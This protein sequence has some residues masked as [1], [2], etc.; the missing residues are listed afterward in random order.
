MQT[1]EINL[2]NDRPPLSVNAVREYNKVTEYLS[3][4]PKRRHYHYNHKELEH[5]ASVLKFT[6]EKEVNRLEK[7]VLDRI[8]FSAFI[9][10]ISDFI[11]K[12]KTLVPIPKYS[13][14]SVSGDFALFSDIFGDLLPECRTDYNNAK[15]RMNFTTHS[16]SQYKQAYF[17][18]SAFSQH[19][20]LTGI[21]SL[22]KVEGEKVT[23]VSYNKRAEMYNN[24]FDRNFIANPG[25]IPTPVAKDLHLEIRDVEDALLACEVMRRHNPYRNTL[26]KKLKHFFKSYRWRGDDV[27]KTRLNALI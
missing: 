24:L 16:S 2:S 27:F 11:I 3:V 9:S 5:T 25:N 19:T 17:S 10:K 1:V 14:G 21:Y 6:L 26:V 13:G 15:I 8:L 4:N 18:C 23:F 20:D 12:E 22:Y 7:E